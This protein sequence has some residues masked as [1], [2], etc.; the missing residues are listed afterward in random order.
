[1][2]QTAIPTQM[3]HGKGYDLP[4]QSYK[5]QLA[6]SHE[7]LVLKLGELEDPL[8]SEGHE[9]KY[10]VGK[11]E[12]GG[13]PVNVHVQLIQGWKSEEADRGMEIMSFPV[14]QNVQDGYQ[15]ITQQIP[16]ERARLISNYGDLFL[17]F[18][19]TRG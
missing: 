1:M 9:L 8:D 15:E 12:K 7:T 17:R 4:S 14:H 10:F 13:R 19:F 2:P 11:T 5:Q 18:T 6:S 3:V 16:S